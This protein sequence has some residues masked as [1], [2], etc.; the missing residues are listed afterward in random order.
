MVTNRQ[1]NLDCSRLDKVA[2]TCGYELK[3]RASELHHPIVPSAIPPFLI[4][5][6][7]SLTIIR[8]PLDPVLFLR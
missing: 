6:P 3:N 8:T 5:F 1:A 2:N 7:F 4:H